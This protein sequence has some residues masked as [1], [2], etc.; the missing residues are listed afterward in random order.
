MRTLTF[1]VSLMCVAL[2]VGAAKADRRVAF[3]VG[4]GAYK[5][6]AQLPNP[7]IDAKAM[8]STLRNVGFEVIE[9]S[10]LT[11]DQM[12][13]KLLDFGRKAQGSDIAVFY[14]AGHGIAVGGTNYLL[15]VDADIKSEMD[16]KLGAAIN[17]DLTLDQTMGDAK[18]KLVFLDACRDN[19]F[20]AK[21]KSNSATRSVN[22]QSG[23]AE[24]KSGEGTLIAFATGPGQT[25]LD[26]QEG[27]NS[28]FTR[29]LIDNITKPGVEIQQ[30]MT[31]VRAQ[32]NEETHKGQLPWGH[33]NLIGAV[34]LNQGPATQVANAAPTAT[35]SPAA[36]A[37]GSEAEVEFWRSVKESNKPEELNAYLSAY[38]NGQFKPLAL[39]RL[40]AIQNGPST[41]TRN[42]NAGVD[43]ATFT[44]DASQLTED[45]I[46]LDKGQRRDVQRR[47]N[48]LGF[49][50]KVTG[51]FNDET[52]SVLKRWQAARGYP[53]TGFLNKLQHKALL[54]E[55]VASTT[56]ASQDSPKPARHAAPPPA[57]SAPV[58]H[59]N[60]AGDAAGAAFVGGVVG[61][62][63]G[64]MF[65]H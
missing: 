1:I 60:S 46:G 53:S 8:A 48:G 49:D 65:R 38:P 34:Y 17:I 58:Q 24:M 29:A 22:V 2:S 40:A 50:T 6:V 36:A 62:M 56:A 64:G 9:G 44:E 55:I 43:P 54:S 11:R 31:S 19:P 15:P 14:Y 51:V 16:V 35:A 10:N 7:P 41:T 57:Q 23:L 4:N 63:M 21:I 42:L 32:V 30:A 61:G 3:V 39:A 59:R 33:T 5:N 13:E 52:R 26:G 25:A 47:L 12:T 18:V 20:A 28:P 45:Q 27:N 37:G